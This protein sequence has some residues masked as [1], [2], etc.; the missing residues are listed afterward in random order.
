VAESSEEGIELS[1]I[2]F[3][4]G[5]MKPV[6]VLPN[7]NGKRGMA[8]CL[9][10]SADGQRLAAGFWDG[11]LRV[12]ELDVRRIA[13]P[14]PQNDSPI[15]I[16][17]KNRRISDPSCRIAHEYQLADTVVPAAISADGRYLAAFTNKDGLQLIDTA[18]GEQQTLWESAGARPFSMVFSRDHR[19]LMVGGSDRTARLWSIPDGRPLLVI[20]TEHVP[21]GM[22]SL[23]QRRLL[24]TAGDSVKVWECDLP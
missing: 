20:N 11:T 5:E 17:Q 23:P 19:W 15:D 2:D 21:N 1:S 3:A 9:A 14:S 6:A 22:L 18:T 7:R 24:I 8:W 10:F 4:A 16:P 12:Y 13:N